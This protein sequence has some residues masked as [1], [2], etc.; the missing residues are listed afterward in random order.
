M[1]PYLNVFIVKEWYRSFALRIREN[2]H[3]QLQEFDHSVKRFKIYRTTLL[4]EHEM[5][6]K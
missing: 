2:P 3:M 6:D 1:K 5:F 4:E